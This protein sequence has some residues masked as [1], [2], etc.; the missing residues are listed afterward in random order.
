MHGKTWSVSARWSFRRCQ[1]SL[2]AVILALSVVL[3]LPVIGSALFIVVRLSAA[4]RKLNEA[5]NLGIARS[6]SS[7]V[8][9]QLLSA[10]A[11]LQALATSSELRHGDFA[12]FYRQSTIVSDRHGARIVLAD[13]SGQ[14]IFNTWRPFGTPLPESPQSALVQ[15]AATTQRTQISDYFVGATA[16]EPLVGVFVPVIQNGATRFVLIM[17]FRPE[18]FSQFFA[19]QHVPEQWTIAVVDRSGVF[20]GHSRALD[21]VIGKP[22]NADLKA[23][24]NSTREGLATL[25]DADGLQVYTAFTR[26]AFSGWTVAF[27][28][29]RAIVDAPLRRSLIEIGVGGLAMMILCGSA[30]LLIAR[31]ISRSMA[32][33]SAAALALGSDERLPPL[34]AS[35]REMDDVIG[36]LSFA[37]AALAKRA[38]QH[39]LAEEALRESEQRFRDI[40]EIGAD[41]IWESDASHRFTLFTGDSLAGPVSSGIAA[42]TTLGKTRWQLAGGNPEVDPHWREH[43][44]E[45]DAHRPFRGFQYSIVGRSESRLFISVNG[46]PVF[47]KN[48]TFRGYRGTATN[49]TDIVEALQRAECAEARL[50][51]A[52]DSISEGFVLFDHHDRLVLCNE[53]YRRMHVESAECIIPGTRFEDILRFAL[54]K[55]QHPDAKGQEEEWLA[56]R[57][58]QHRELTGTVEQQL[59]NGRWLLISEQRMSDGGTAGLR[60]DITAFKAVQAE[61]HASREHLARAQRVAATG[62]FELDLRTRNIE[63]SDETY[64][65]FGVTRAIGPLNQTALEEII[66]PEDRERFRHQIAIVL[67]GRSEP[68]MEYRIRRADGRIRTL[69]REM[70]LI[71]DAAHQPHKLIGVIRDV[72]ELRDAERRRDELER[73]LMHSQ[74][75][76]ALG[77]LAGGV[78]HD[79]NNTLV[80]ILALSKLAVDELPETSPVRADIETI[81]RASERARDLVKQILA[82]SRKRDVLKQEVDLG[83]VTREA[84]QMLRASL[85]ASIHIIEQIGEVPPVFG[86]EGELHQVVINLMTNAA[87]AIGGAAGRI[88]VSIWSAAEPPISPHMRDVGPVVCLSIADTGCGMDEATLNR[89]FEPFFTT[90]EVGDGTGLG[91]SVV[92]GIVNGHGGRITV[93]SSLGEGSEFTLALR[94]IDQHQRTAQ[95]E[96]VAA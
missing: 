56:E 3:I 45:L 86:D 24:M 89:V 88:T 32:T 33:L 8:D 73:Q 57:L 87:Q 25:P 90:K 65:I 41:W 75:L 43:K 22:V 82:F 62:S 44:A 38:D 61:L 93:R 46:K 81:I 48:R 60:V 30:A 11:A 63:W 16:G 1:T 77:T 96:T 95:V 92:H 39:R 70:E 59:A 5:Q 27:G 28:L 31:R 26:S 29:P 72:T 9:R 84:L 94:A 40:A 6:F 68:V 23:A 49:V 85:P 19:D 50:R 10:E 80:P 76:E 53:T 13:A 17:A 7:E 64:R 15:I 52:V 91:L 18:K 37:A 51:D 78:A 69:Y 67:E 74:K 34:C 79:L 21:R 42:A 4:E 35:V 55:G 47:N 20:V 71:R 54:A 58:K 66:L 12:E 14:M 83:L 2:R 36:S